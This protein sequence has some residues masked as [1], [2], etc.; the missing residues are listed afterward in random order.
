MPHFPPSSRDP[1]DDHQSLDFDDIPPFPTDVPTAP[2]LRIS[3]AKL[4][5]HD[6][7]EEEALF[8][9]CRDLGFFYLDL[10]DAK[11]SSYLSLTDNEEVISNEEK[12]ENENPQ[13][14]EDRN[15]I[16]GPDLLSLSTSLFALAPDI[17]SLPLS[18]KQKYDFV[19]AG[20]YFG[21]KGLGQAIVDRKGTRDG[22]EFWNLSK[23]DLLGYTV[24]RLPNPSVLRDDEGN[25]AVLARYCIRAHAVV[26]LML[27]ILETKLG[28]EKGGL[29]G[30]HRLQETSGDQIRWVRA[31]PQ[32]EVDEKKLALGEHTDFGSVT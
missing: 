32:K 31:P 23:D 28:L 30:L 4:L 17:F 15:I 2:L 29:E 27:G 18:E 1:N 22:N 21:Y 6:V 13:K 10:R 14:R 12:E 19:A 3:L 8:V 9:A 24:P 20:S 16:S 7:A 11:S 26:R 25:R 5:A